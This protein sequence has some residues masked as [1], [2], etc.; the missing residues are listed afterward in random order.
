V[1]FRRTRT[2][3]FIA[4]NEVGF[5]FSLRRTRTQDF[6]SENGKVFPQEKSYSTIL[7]YE[8]F[9]RNTKFFHRKTRIQDF[10]IKNGKGFLRRS[11]T[12]Y[13]MTENDSFFF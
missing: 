13:F 6:V 11:R 8:F 3:G 9:W 4:E 10:V 7:G 1:D 12:Q 2:Q 5:F